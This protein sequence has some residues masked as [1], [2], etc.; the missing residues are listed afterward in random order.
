MSS[1]ENEPTAPA[2]PWTGFEP[3][4]FR[5]TPF[6]FGVAFAAL[7]VMGVTDFSSDDTTAWMWVVG[8]VV[9]GVGGIVAS[10]SRRRPA[11]TS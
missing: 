11:A 5:A 2:T 4:R 6:V 10:L 9:F 8:L 3:H 1:A 7:G